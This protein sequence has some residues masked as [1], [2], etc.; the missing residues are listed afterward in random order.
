MTDNNGGGAVDFNNLLNQFDQLNIDFKPFGFQF[1]LADGGDLPLS[2]LEI[3]SRRH[4]ISQEKS[5]STI[6]NAVN[7]FISKH[8]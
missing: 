4:E 3:Y 5:K 8:I 6:C 7:V 2:V 1:Y